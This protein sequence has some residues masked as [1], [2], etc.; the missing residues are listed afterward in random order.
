MAALGEGEYSAWGRERGRID[1]VNVR[2]VM[3]AGIIRVANRAE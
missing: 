2:V 3:L 1:I